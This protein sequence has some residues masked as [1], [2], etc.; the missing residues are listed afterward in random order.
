[1]EGIGEVEKG[2]EEVEDEVIIWTP[3]GGSDAEDL[4]DEGT[5]EVLRSRAKSGASSRLVTGPLTRMM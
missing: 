2:E 1:M 3:S 5:S 4:L